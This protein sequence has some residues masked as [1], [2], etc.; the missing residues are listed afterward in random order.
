MNKQKISTS[1]KILDSATELFLEKGVDRVS[2]REIAA[3]A[4]VNLSLM[5]YYFHSKENLFE[6]IFERL[7]KEKA[8]QLRDILESE[9]GVEEKIRSYINE[10]IN[11]LLSQ[12]IL[13]SF[14]LS[15]VHRNPDKVKNMDSM[16]LLYNSE[17]F[18]NHIRLEVDAGNINCVD[19]EQLY[20]SIISLILF[21]FAIDELIMDRNGFTPQ[22]YIDFVLARKDHVLDMVLAY[23]RR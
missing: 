3:K 15:I 6:I 4:G 10:Y 19:P 7:I 2:V 9:L 22:Q 8:K 11:M 18:C 21:P 16:L 13:V 12:P 20:V 14:V 1:Q 23:I 5:N 17:L